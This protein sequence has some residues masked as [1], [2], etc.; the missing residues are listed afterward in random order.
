M[1]LPW[2]I[3]NDIGCLFPLTCR[4]HIGPICKH[5]IFLE[6]N[7]LKQ[8]SQR[9][10]SWDTHHFCESH[11]YGVLNTVEFLDNFVYAFCLLLPQII[12]AHAGGQMYE[13]TIRQWRH[14]R[15][16]L[17]LIVLTRATNYDSVRYCPQVS[18]SIGGFS[19]GC[20]GLWSSW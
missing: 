10:R 8:F 17:P 2:I 12:V 13:Q 11:W 1:Q 5:N 4:L 9:K 3:Y 15:W 19:G 6:H 14:H 7:K 18:S 16:T 20:R